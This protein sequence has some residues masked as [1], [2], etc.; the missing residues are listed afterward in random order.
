MST[1]E[2]A[3]HKIVACSTF[4][5]AQDECLWQEKERL[6]GI[7]TLLCLDVHQ[8][9]SEL[10]DLLKYIS[11]MPFAVISRLS[12]LI[13]DKF[14]IMLKTRLDVWVLK[15]MMSFM[16]RL[17][18]DE[19]TANKP[20]TKIFNGMVVSSSLGMSIKIPS[21]MNKNQ[22][23]SSIQS[24][25]E[26]ISMLYIVR[27]KKLY[28]H[29]FMDK[30]LTSTCEWNNEFLEEQEKHCGWTEGDGVAPYPFDAKFCFSNDAIIYALNHRD[31]EH[32]IPKY[33]VMK[34][35]SKID[36]DTYVHHL[37][38][39]RGC[40][41]EISDRSNITDLHS[42][43]LHEALKLYGANDY[44]EERCRTI[45]VALDYLDPLYV[46][47]YCMSEKEQRGGGRPIATGRRGHDRET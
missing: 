31:R 41:K 10:L 13:N 44:E 3:G 12:R 22:R 27:G 6:V 1:W 25:I 11:F 35:L 36:Y 33:K 14:N 47:Q 29:Q 4:L 39:L 20:V 17:K 5:M 37:T 34:T 7:I 30:S 32:P 45:P 40:T 28:G 43:S 21:F 24:F 8:K 42:T 19:I 46:P 9:I 15:E 16:S 26:E 23:Y 38:S 2:Q 18:L